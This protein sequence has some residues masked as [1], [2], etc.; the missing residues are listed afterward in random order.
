MSFF[1]SIMAHLGITKVV[2]TD[3]KIV[4]VDEFAESRTADKES[5]LK[6]MVET[7][8]VTQLIA[9]SPNV[10]AITNAV[11]TLEKQQ[12]AQASNITTQSEK[13]AALEASIAS[14]TAKI[15]A[16]EAAMAN[17]QKEFGDKIASLREGALPKPETEGTPPIADNDKKNG[18]S[19]E[20]I[21][22]IDGRFPFLKGI[23]L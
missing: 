12:Q 23:Q 21:K 13:I 7:E 15:A 17:T 16:L 18:A 4:A 19:A 6:T 1:K 3:N 5:H 11:S 2:A 22:K 14:A 8:A 10:T 20:T 9:E